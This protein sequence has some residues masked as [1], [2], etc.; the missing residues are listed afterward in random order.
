MTSSR[1]NT[2]GR[3]ERSRTIR[4]IFDGKAYTGH[5]GD[6]LASALLANGVTLFGRSFKYHRPRGVFAA[7]SE[8]PNALVTLIDSEVR[9]PNVRATEAEI[10][11]GLVAESQNRFPSLEHDL[12]AVNQLAGPLF[13][14]G[15]YYKTF[16]GPAIGPLRGTRFWM[17]CEKFIR[18]AAGLGRAGMAADPDRYERMNAYCDVLVVGTGPA[19]LI[20][21]ETAAATGARVIIAEERPVAGGSLLSSGELI[22]GRNPAVWAREKAEL[23]AGLPNVRF[24]TRTTVWG[25]YDGNVLAAIEHVA[26]FKPNRT[27]GQPRQRHWVIRTGKTILATG[28]FERPIVFPGNDRPGVML[29]DAVRRFAMEY[30]VAA[31]SNIAL[32]TNNDS[33]YDVARTLS[34]AGVGIGT[35]IDVRTDVSGTCRDIADVA[36]AELLLGHA[37]TATHAGKTLSSITVQHFNAQTGRVSGAPREIKT[38]CLGVSGGWSPAIHLASQAGGK[39]EWDE[40]L[41]AF[42]APEAHQNW[43]VAGSA[44][45]YMDTISVLSDAAT[46][47]SAKHR[48]AL[49][50]VDAPMFDASPAPVFQIEPDG[51][52]QKAFVDLQ[53]DVTA[54]D[55]RLAYREGFHSVE[56]LKRYTT[57]GMATDQGKTSNVPGLAIMADARQIPIT[58]A[59]TTR[60]R[61][62]FTPVSLGALAGERYGDL[63]PHR[64]TPMHD[65]HLSAGATMYDAGLWHRPMIYGSPGE[66]IEQAYIREARTVRDS[67]GIVDVSTLG[68]IDI[69]GPDAA[70]FL[71]RVYT[72]MFST[73]P[74]GKARYGLMLRED[75]IVFDDGTTWRLGQDQFLMTTTTANAGPVM[76]HLEYYLDCIW[77]DLRVHLT[78]VTDVWAGAAIA[79]PKSRAVLESCVT[80]SKVDD[81]TLPFM[82]IVHARIGD[83]PVMIC[84]LSFS[85]ELAYEVYCGAGFGTA[86]WEALISAGTPFGIVPYGLEALGTL[87]IEKGHVTG[88]EIDGRTTAHDLH[89]DWMLSKKKPFIGSAML[90][91]EGLQDNNRLS[92]VGLI[93]LDNQPINGGSHIVA[94]AT[95][96][97]PADSFGHVTA[98][99]Y[100]PALG[101]YVALALVKHGSSMIGRRAYASDLLRDKHGPVEIVSHHMFDREGS[102]MHG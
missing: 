45:G 63:R 66:T 5:P 67:V 20:A 41:Q 74:I 15:F 4:F 37:V 55:I 70:E 21:A 46:K 85:G 69:Q 59:G 43:V 60:F 34:Q 65:W 3:I 76:Q 88:A 56:H 24:L 57:L 13:S 18:R 14:A 49:P 72:N 28:A 16:M 83:I 96:R 87:R 54:D 75:G 71:D 102:R 29:A 17:F 73:L 62:P 53:H 101:K 11:D 77:P 68:K 92:L 52:T 94:D 89:L 80:A 23:L 22:D 2:G 36:G 26:D 25:H 12:M 33:A 35:I 99:C 93:S 79:G 100:S 42:L 48:A 97:E 7:G 84:R 78:S 81:A 90:R 9:E 6:T 30:G 82:G 1:L 27:E 86:M 31:G 44:A 40:D 64:L 38:D 61:P 10:H 39:P 47:G 58:A 19:G 51:K 50:T 98:A 91:R 8:E 95:P 32:F